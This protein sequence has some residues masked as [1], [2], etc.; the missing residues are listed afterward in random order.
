MQSLDSDEVILQ[1]GKHIF[2]GS[3][4]ES[5]GTRILISEGKIN[6]SI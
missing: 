5:I 2:Q 4:K 1:L 3:Y 6:F